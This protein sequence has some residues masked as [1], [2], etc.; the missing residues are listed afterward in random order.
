MNSLIQMGTLKNVLELN[1]K[2]YNIMRLNDSFVLLVMEESGRI[3]GPFTDDASVGI[4]WISHVLQTPEGFRRFLAD[5]NWNIGGDRVWLAPEFPF[6]TK[7]R[8]KF[9]ET[10]IVQPGIDP[11][12][13]KIAEDER[14]YLT[15]ESELHAQLFEHEHPDKSFHIKRTLRENANPIRNITEMGALLHD[16]R[17][18][19]YEQEIYVTDNS[20]QY[21]MQL[22]IWNLLQVRPGG[23]FLIPYLGDRFN[24]VDYYAPSMNRVLS[25]KRQH[26]EIKVESAAEHKIGVSAF[27]TFGRAGY[28]MQVTADQWALL[29][30]NYYNDPSSAYIKEPSDQPGKTG[31]SLFVYMN[32]TR[33]D[34]HA[35][36]ETTGKTFGLPLN[37]ESTLILNYWYYFGTLENLKQIVKLLLGVNL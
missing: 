22:E 16:V 5:G 2:K 13:Y 9:N 3:F 8:D 26:A 23:T 35:E 32:D 7:E 24:Y 6:F 21:N 15:M 19:G 14:G 20:P 33:G 28:L 17:Y 10:Y 12:H 34:G 27:N 29:I 1:H 18:C 11:G 4:T 30:R 36:L 37:Q 31:C 25:V